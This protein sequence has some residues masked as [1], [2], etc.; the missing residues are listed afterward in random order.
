MQITPEELSD[1]Y[2]FSIDDPFAPENEIEFSCKVVEN[3]DSDILYNVT[4]DDVNYSLIEDGT[5]TIS[6]S[7]TASYEKG[8]ASAKAI[9]IE[10]GITGIENFYEYDN[11]ISIIIPDTVT[12]IKCG[13]FAGCDSLTTLSVNSGNAKYH[14]SGNC[15]IETQSK[16]LISGCKNSTIPDD[17]S[18][19]NIASYAFGNCIG[20]TSIVV[21]DSVTSIAS[22]A[23][24]GC[25]ALES[26]TIPFVGGG[27]KLA[28][29]T[30]QYPFGYIFGSSS[31]EG[32]VST[33]QYYSNNLETRFY[34]PSSLKSV[35]VTG[36]NISMGAFHN[37]SSLTSITI[38][39]SVTSIGGNAFSGC[40]ALTS[41]TIPDS[42]T[43]ID[44]GAFQYCD[45]LT[46]ITI[47]DGVTIIGSLAFSNCSSLTSITI[48]DSV[49]SIYGSAFSGCSALTSITIPDS[50]TSIGSSAFYNCDSLTSITIPDNVTS[51][52]SGAFSGCS[53][54]ESITI[55]FVGGSVKTAIDTYQYPFGYIFGTSSY[56]GGVST[57][58]YYY[59][60]STSS[61]TN[62]YYT[63][64]YYYIP[65]SLKSVTVTGGNILYGAFYGCSSLES[66]VIPD[67]ATSI[68]GN[69]FYNCSSLASINIPDSVTSIG[70]SAFSGCG[71]LKEVH[72]SDIAA[73]CAIDFESSYAN[74]LCNDGA[75]YLNGEI[76]TSLEIPDS[77]TS[78][79]NSAF[80]ECSSITSIT[81]GGSVT[82]IGDRAFSWCR[83]LISIVIPD[84]VTSIGEGAFCWCDSL[85]SINIP[86]SVTSIGDRAFYYCS[87]LESITIPDGV[88]SIGD[89]AFS[90][91][92][93]LESITIP[94]SVTSIGS[95]AF[96]YCSSFESITIPD[97]VTSIG[98]GA[99]SWCTS[100]TSINFQGSIAQWKAID[101]G[102]DWTNGTG[103]FTIACTDG[104]L[105]KSGNQVS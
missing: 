6:G 92:S 23:F 47:P 29:D 17:G 82:S 101:K 79:G 77:V 10:E 63:N 69:A 4:I 105:D 32:G 53:G 1:S 19:T 103:S 73:W 75:L 16:T 55:P 52:G 74:P 2:T 7:G 15:V 71:S 59:G 9:I 81:I 83:S 98:D 12:E 57:R 5:L 49:T 28:Y 39:D 95:L 99:F 66:I 33:R 11:A 65:S 20:L 100:L 58:Q 93:S 36:G 54:L 14:S 42:V 60:S 56:E 96:Y 24:S 67:S 84:S 61:T 18:V 38:P 70:S 46:S 41:I 62:S 13:A 45:S 85:E 8:A 78:I 97:S 104:T 76:V 26:I 102:Y 35:I 25:S 90:N 43:I 50:V 22:G 89:R 87:S 48:G 21:P 94:D 80:Y 3:P 88:T 68:G 72:I 40:S 30:Y 31:Y 34:I 44:N 37:C 86:D 64:S 27:M 51:I 91:C